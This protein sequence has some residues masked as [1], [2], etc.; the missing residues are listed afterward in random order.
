MIEAREI[1]RILQ[2]PIQS[3]TLGELLNFVDFMQNA[4]PEQLSALGIP[5][6]DRD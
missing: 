3:L 4:T 5:N 1:A 6:L 2:Q